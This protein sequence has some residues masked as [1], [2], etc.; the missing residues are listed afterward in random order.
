MRLILLATAKS[1][2]VSI[3]HAS[4]ELLHTAAIQSAQKHFFANEY[5]ALI[6]MDLTLEVSPMIWMAA[7]YSTLQSGNH[8]QIRLV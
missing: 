2:A 5:T 6:M 3:E 8:R 4:R 1:I 7:L